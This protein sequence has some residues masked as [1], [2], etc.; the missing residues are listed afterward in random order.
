MGSKRVAIGRD[1]SEVAS[2]GLAR[3]EGCAP[4]GY[5]DREF[6]W[7]VV[8][9]GANAGQSVGPMRVPKGHG[10]CH[11]PRRRP[12]KSTRAR[13]ATAGRV[14]RVKQGM[15]VN[16]G[17]CR[18]PTFCAKLACSSMP[19]SRVAT[20]RRDVAAAAA[21]DLARGLNGL[22]AVAVAGEVKTGLSVEGTAICSTSPVA[23]PAR[24]RA[25]RRDISNPQPVA[26]QP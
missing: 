2:S 11:P 19:P 21:L 17:G 4:G 14:D 16:R 1:R 7:R 9:S 20:A 25:R 13:G 15:R 6:V 3:S 10:G 22:I 5:P 18:A 23:A 24:R 8:R 26:A 12:L